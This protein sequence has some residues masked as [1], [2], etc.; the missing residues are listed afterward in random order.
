M[1]LEKITN[2]L[3]LVCKNVSRSQLWKTSS[4][5]MISVQSLVTK[6]TVYHDHVIYIFTL[7]YFHVKMRLGEKD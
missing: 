5:V 7:E 6:E 2:N 1:K 3:N 4:S